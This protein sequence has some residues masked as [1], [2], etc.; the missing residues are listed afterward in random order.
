ML[1]S[2]SPPSSLRRR[3]P[4]PA[5]IAGAAVLVL[6]A[7]SSSGGQGPPSS[8]GAGSAGGATSSDATGGGPPADAATTR[9]VRAAYVTFFDSKTSAAASE[10][11]LQH[12]ASFAENLAEQAKTANAEAAS[13]KVSAVR[14]AGRDVADVT[15][16]L[17]SNGASLLQ[18]VSGKA[19]REGG[20]W[21]VAAKTFCDL[22]ALQ[23][24]APSAC[25]DPKITAL[26]H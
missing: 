21:K 5:T 22:L 4:L 14:L 11:V 7:C 2:V 1:G 25:K 13:A 17:T 6:A 24:D 9:A 18:D 8:T 12:G 3:M 20:R 26:P 23:G 16:T 19:V 10:T 15:Y